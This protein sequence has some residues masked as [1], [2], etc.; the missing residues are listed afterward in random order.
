MHRRVIELGVGDIWTIELLCL[1]TKPSNNPSPFT[2]L[3]QTPCSVLSPFPPHLS[4][5]SPRPTHDALSVSQPVPCACAAATA[6][7]QKLGRGL[8]QP[9]AHATLAA[10]SLLWRKLCLS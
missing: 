3:S 6:T 9:R 4:P 8:A 1:S 10:A 2:L 7:L 5:L